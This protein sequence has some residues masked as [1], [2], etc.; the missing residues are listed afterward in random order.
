MRRE[1]ATTYWFGWGYSSLLDYATSTTKVTDK[2]MVNVIGK[3]YR[4]EPD[5]RF[6]EGAKGKIDGED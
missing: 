5:V 1:S 4:G 6:D 2:V 3:P